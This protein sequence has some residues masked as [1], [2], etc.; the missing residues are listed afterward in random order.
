MKSELS[1]RLG[2]Y[3][4]SSGLSQKELSRITGVSESVI[5]RVIKGECEMG[6]KNLVKITQAT[7]VSPNWLLGY[8]DAFDMTYITPITSNPDLTPTEKYYDKN[9][10]LSTIQDDCKDGVI[11]YVSGSGPSPK[12]DAHYKAAMQ[13]NNTVIVEKGFCGNHTNYGAMY[14]GILECVARITKPVN[15]YII[16]PVPLGI[17]SGGN[18]NSNLKKSIIH[19]LVKNG[20]SVTTVYYHG[21]ADRLKSYIDFC[22]QHCPVNSVHENPIII[23][24]GDN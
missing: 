20:C 21:G 24:G 6:T 19:Y 14:L 2:L 13:Y 18:K 3:L 23:K 17:F 16:A 5:C 1:E 22:S 4:E 11:I 9:T 8:G 12:C 7:K 10:S 15:V